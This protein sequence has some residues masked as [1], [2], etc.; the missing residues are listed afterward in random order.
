MGEMTLL[1]TGT[2]EGRFEIEVEHNIRDI[3]LGSK[4]KSVEA[5]WKRRERMPVDN[6]MEEVLVRSWCSSLAMY[7]YHTMGL[8]PTHESDW[9]AFADPGVTNSIID[10]VMIRK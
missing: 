10:Y 9:L 4:K 8:L 6:N 7:K 2:G 5:V 3:A 1:H